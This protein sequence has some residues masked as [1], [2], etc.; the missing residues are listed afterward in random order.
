MVSKNEEYITLLYQQQRTKLIARENWARQI[1]KELIREADRDFNLMDSIENNPN[2]SGG[3]Q[4][5][6]RLGR[7]LA[8]Y[9]VAMRF[10]L[11]DLAG[12]A[13]DLMSPNLNNKITEDQDGTT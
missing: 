13:F 7:R 11:G 9:K 10:G 6:L 8:A 5:G 3:Y 4:V 2:W 1:V 12:E